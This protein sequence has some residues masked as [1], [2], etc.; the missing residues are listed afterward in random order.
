[1]HI[2]FPALS[3]PCHL[4]FTLFLKIETSLHGSVF[5]AVTVKAWTMSQRWLQWEWSGERLDNWEAE[6]RKW[7]AHRWDSAGVLQGA[8]FGQFLYSIYVPT[9][10][11]TQLSASLWSFSDIS[12]TQQDFQKGELHPERTLNLLITLTTG[13]K[14][15]NISSALEADFHY[16]NEVHTLV[17]SETKHT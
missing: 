8:V 6:G 15:V 7:R 12:E 5:P 17:S 11:I 14:H 1:M 13:V 3:N 16:C 2:I 4:S 10:L 9:G